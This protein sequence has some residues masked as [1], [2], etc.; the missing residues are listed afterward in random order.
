[1]KTELQ[2]L[3][4]TRVHLL[5]LIKEHHELLELARESEDIEFHTDAILHLT[6]DYNV[7]MY[8]LRVEFDKR[9]FKHPGWYPSGKL[10]RELRRVNAQATQRNEGVATEPTLPDI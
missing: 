7:S 3:L 10:V 8:K 2:I 5:R 6:R 9:E 4:T 1:M